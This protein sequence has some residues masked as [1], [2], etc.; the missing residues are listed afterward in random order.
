MR[1]FG[2]IL[3]SILL[4]AS[5]IAARAQVVYSATARN[6]SIT[7][8]GTASVFQPDFE[9]SWATQNAPVVP[10]TIPDVICIPLAQTSHYPLFG[11]GAYVDVRLKRWVQ[12]E[13]E[14]RWQRWNQY[15]GIGSY[16]GIYQDNYLIGPRLPI[17]RFWKATVYGTALG[18]FSKMNFGTFYGSPAGH[19]SFTDLAFG[20]GMDIKLTRKL[21]FRAAD[22]EYQYWPSWSNTHLS[23]YGASVG[24]GYKIF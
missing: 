13:A 11:A 4:A 21:S 15:G 9:G 8:G 7:A 22:V 18:G 12:F 19:G 10:C 2:A 17:Y 16:A 14:A 1:Q 3:F 6:V 24:V 23:P 20:G 5:A